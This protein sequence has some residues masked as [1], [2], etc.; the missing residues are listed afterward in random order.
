MSK[1]SYNVDNFET[2]VMEKKKLIRC[3]VCLKS[4]LLWVSSIGHQGVPVTLRNPE[5]E[6]RGAHTHTSTEDVV[7]ATVGIVSSGALCRRSYSEI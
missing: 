3:T 7:I 4:K 1:A 2:A 5:A 6:R